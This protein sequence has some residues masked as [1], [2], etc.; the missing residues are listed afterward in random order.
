MST[1]ISLTKNNYRLIIDTK[2]YPEAMQKNYLSENKKF[3]SGN[4]YQIFTYVKNSDFTGE[5]SGMLLYPTVAYD[6]NQDY[7]LSG[8]N[9]FI[10]TVDL[11]KDFN[12][13]SKIL[14]DIGDLV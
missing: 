8:N 7:K 11:N 4:L 10:K 9:V 1:D 5:V 14:K 2:F 13:I 3:I 6:L 12:E